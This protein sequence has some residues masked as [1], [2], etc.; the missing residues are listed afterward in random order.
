MGRIEWLTGKYPKKGNII[1]PSPDELD[2][3]AEDIA[4]K[5]A[6]D[7]GITDPKE[8]ERIK[9]Y[10]KA[11]AKTGKVI[12]KAIAAD[13]PYEMRLAK[14]SGSEALN[15][16]IENLAKQYIIREEIA[17]KHHREQRVHKEYP[18][19]IVGTINEYHK[20]VSEELAKEL[21]PKVYKLLESMGPIL[22]GQEQ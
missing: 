18:P 8:K 21:K 5:I 16:E 19:E 12:G 6:L 10:V 13:D 2:K 20:K 17:R 3:N 14:V 1:L 11:V 4:V 9:E 22:K 15:L 7:L